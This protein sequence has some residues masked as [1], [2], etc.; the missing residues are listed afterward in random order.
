MENPLRAFALR[1][2]A[3]AF[4]LTRECIFAIIDWR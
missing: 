4:E 3:L 1:A 2:G